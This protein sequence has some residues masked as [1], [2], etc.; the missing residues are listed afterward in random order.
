MLQ[1][2]LSGG[3]KIM[4]HL[5]VF[6]GISYDFMFRSDDRAPDADS[7]APFIAGYSDNRYVHKLGFF[8]GIQF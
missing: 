8:G 3:Y 2:R 6:A 1:L 5:G 7:F 4:P